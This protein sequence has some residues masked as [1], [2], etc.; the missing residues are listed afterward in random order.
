MNQRHPKMKK[1]AALLL[2]CLLILAS[3][4]LFLFVAQNE[5]MIHWMKT[6]SPSV[7]KSASSSEVIGDSALESRQTETSLSAS[8]LLTVWEKDSNLILVNWEYG[9]PD[10]YEPHLVKAYDMEMDERIMEPYRQ[11]AA[12][13]SKDGV[14]LWISSAYRA[15][16]LQKE[17]L[18][19]EIQENEKKGMSSAEAK[20]KAA[21]AVAAPGHSEHNT[22]LAIDVNGVRPDFEKEKGYEWLQKHAAEYGFILRYP[23]DKEK[24][25]KIMFEPWHYRYVGKENAQKMKELGMS[26]EEYVNYLARNE[27]NN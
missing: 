18:E 1:T 7:S 27:E 23:K 14:T 22:G 5:P 4:V 19:R 20:E 25:T 21:A 17:L 10:H 11:M 24:I 3:S 12:A 26:L 8:E 6:F 15:P 2:I 9:L 16:E 13:A